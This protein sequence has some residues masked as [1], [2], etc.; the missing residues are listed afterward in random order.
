MDGCVFGVTTLLLSADGQPGFG[1]AQV[2]I[3]LDG[4]RG[5][6][7]GPAYAAAAGWACIEAGQAGRIIS[8]VDY[9]CKTVVAWRLMALEVDRASLHILHEID[10]F[11]NSRLFD[12]IFPVMKLKLVVVI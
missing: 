11:G 3:R 10:I 4:T 6:W 7:D 9:L 2:G 8:S 1:I 5:S 12:H